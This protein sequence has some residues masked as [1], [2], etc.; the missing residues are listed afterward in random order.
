M[1]RYFVEF[2]SISN[3]YIVH[4]ERCIT[5]P[6]TDLATLPRMRQLGEFEEDVSALALARHLYREP[7][8]CY[9]C[10]VSRYRESVLANCLPPRS[11]VP[12]RS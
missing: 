2:S 1:N 8:P 9:C 7:C 6:D 3:S 5:Y 12:V 10:F 4:R 11:S